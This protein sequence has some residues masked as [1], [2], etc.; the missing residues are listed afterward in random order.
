MKQNELPKIRLV[1]RD[2]RNLN[3]DG[4]QTLNFYIRFLGKT[5]KKPT[6]V[7]VNPKNWDKKKRIIV[8]SSPELKKHQIELNEKM[9]EFDRYFL[10]LSLSRRDIV[11]NR[12]SIH[13]FFDNVKFDD[14]C[15]YYLKIAEEKKKSKSSSTYNK[16]LNA[17]HVFREF[18]KSKRLDDLRF[19]DVTPRL[20]K[21]FDMHMVYVKKLHSTSI[22]TGYHQKLRY[23]FDRAVVEDIIMKSPYV[24]L[25]K[26]ESAPNPPRIPLTEDEVGRM[27]E[28]E[29]DH[30]NAHLERIRD[31]F[32][33]YCY[34]GVRFG[35][36]FLIKKSKLMRESFEH[37]DKKNKR[38]VTKPLTAKARKLIHKY[39]IEMDDDFCFKPLSNGY[40]NRMLKIVAELAKI[41]KNV[42]SH[43]GRHT[44]ATNLRRNN[45]P[46]EDIGEILC[47][48][49]PKTPLTYAKPNTENLLGYM[50]NLYAGKELR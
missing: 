36:L 48:K 37:Y 13:D 4:K 6:G 14:F 10:Q 43:L 32:L 31:Y 42:F 38:S 25:K 2:D 23:V 24:G 12:Q 20:I 27:V 9:A 40:Y 1:L 33:F 15:A 26:E 30:E 3:A 35:E 17:L 21:D 5:T 29:F 39:A 16:Y 46:I 45:V 47:Q 22:E 19:V 41:E 11:I 8:G 34:T 49:D 18:C 44:L 50:Q 28:L 7:F